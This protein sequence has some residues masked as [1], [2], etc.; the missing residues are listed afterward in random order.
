MMEDTQLTELL[1]IDPETQQIH[2]KDRRLVLIETDALGELR[3]DLISTLG[4]ERAKGFLLRYG[5]KCGENYART[6]KDMMPS[7]SDMDWLHAGPEIHRITGDVLVKTEKL[8][9]DP[10]TRDYYA[11]GYWYHSYEAEQHLK[12]YGHYH[13]AV[14]FTLLGYAGGYVSQHLGR[15]VLFHE[16]ECVG[17]GDAHCHWVAKPIED[18]DD[19]TRS[20]LRYYQE[21]NLV[22]EL[23]KAYVRIEQQKEMLRKVLLIDEQLSSEL[24]RRKGLSSIINILGK[25]LKCIVN[26]EDKNFEL[27]ESY[28]PSREGEFA[29]FVK[30]HSTKENQVFNRL[31]VQKRTVH[32]PVPA[33]FGWK[34]ERL[35]APIIVDKEVW[36]YISLIKESGDFTEM[37]VMCIERAATIC[38]IQLLNERIS[39]ETEERIRGEFFDEILNGDQSVENLTRRMKVLG[40]NLHRPQYVFV[41]NFLHPDKDLSEGGERYL[42]ELRR[43]LASSI[44]DQL[45]QIGGNCLISSKLEQI[46]V[47]IPEDFTRVINRDARG[48]GQLIVQTLMNRYRDLDITVGISTLCHRMEDFR[49]GYDEAKK[50][51]KLAKLK[52]SSCN[53]ASFT[54]LGLIAYLCNDDNV[55]D[56]K[57]FSI[58]TLGAIIDYDS[59]NKSELAKTLHYYFDN[60]GNILKTSRAMN[61]S[62]GSIK[63]RLKRIEEITGLN[64]ETSKDFF[65]THSALMILEYFGVVEF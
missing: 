21:E 8:N 4:M 11:E 17:K 50:A 61:M 60:Q 39:L 63:Y 58:R 46:I 55:E 30:Q 31:I 26:I 45:K 54:D 41:F 22:E 59:H 62:A 6:F 29:Q 7:H 18:W 49:R 28:G 25:H 51:I 27:F 14:C 2:M 1:T 12:H 48:M 37:E 15:R 44:F 32:L 36:G 19:E 47:L 43:Q 23:D 64:L 52:N 5:W 20:Q 57:R 9:F 65:D 24:L 34:H 53:V 13:E 33:E 40:Y 38:A 56:M 10:V 35:I 3:K 42:D 16:I